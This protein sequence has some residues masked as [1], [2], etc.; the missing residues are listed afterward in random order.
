[1]K[2]IQNL[3]SKKSFS[4]QLKNGASTRFQRGVTAVELIIGLAVIGLVIA[5]V[6]VTAQSTFRDQKINDEAQ[7]VQMLQSKVR[8][9]VANSL[10]TKNATI[11]NLASSKYIPLDSLDA[12]GKKMTSKFGYPVA[13]VPAKVVGDNDSVQIIY[14][15]LNTDECINFAKAAG[16][17]FN[18]VA[19]IAS[20]GT[21][22]GVATAPT[23]TDVK[24]INKPLNESTLLTD[25]K[26]N[27]PANV[28]F[29][30]TKA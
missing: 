13:I 9:Y 12:D 28:V 20:T 3:M 7:R 27:N 19:V 1:M 21:T 22:A 15:G 29:T 18:G 24:A 25:C 10:D 14:S 23:A 6:A 8:A 26:K 16:S 2:A 30:M 5:G 4:N 17:A 11:E